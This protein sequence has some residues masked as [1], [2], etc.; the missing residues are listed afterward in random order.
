MSNNSNQFVTLGNTVTHKN[1]FIDTVDLQASTLTVNN[2]NY[3]INAQ[4]KVIIDGVE[5]ALTDLAPDQRVTI[6]LPSNE[7]T[8]FIKAEIVTL[9]LNNNTATVKTQGKKEA[10]SIRLAPQVKVTG[11]A[12]SLEQL[13]AGQMVKLRLAKKI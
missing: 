11:K 9:D 7:K 12:N 5:R 4:T 10:I 2:K 1:G 8:E 13:A 3:R 6:K